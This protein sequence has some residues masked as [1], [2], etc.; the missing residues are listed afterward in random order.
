MAHQAVFLAVLQVQ[1]VKVAKVR[2]GSLEVL[3][4]VLEVELVDLA[5]R[6][7]FETLV[8]AKMENLVPDLEA[9]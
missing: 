8:L 9:D 5:I 6:A 1:V 2:V 3:V 7:V 4:A